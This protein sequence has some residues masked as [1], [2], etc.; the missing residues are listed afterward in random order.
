MTTKGTQQT[1]K[2]TQTFEL[3]S[4][5][6]RLIAFIIDGILLGIVG[7]LFGL[8]LELV[9]GSAISLLVGAGYQWYFLTQHKGQTPGKMVMGIYVIKADGTKIS[10]TDAILRYVGY[11]IGSV[12]IGLG[13]LWAFFNSNKQGWHDMIAKTYV[14]TSPRVVRVEYD[15]YLED[16]KAKNDYL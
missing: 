16:S 9:G 1:M 7:G 12:I 10:D 14:V 6:K 13:F 15:E 4:R 3:A 5:F 2:T 8:Q 11:V